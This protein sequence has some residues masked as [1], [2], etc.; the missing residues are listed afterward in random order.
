MRSNCIDV[1]FHPNYLSLTRLILSG[2]IPV[3]FIYF[4]AA[5]LYI[6]FAISITDALDGY[7]A[8]K[9]NLTTQLG[10]LLDSFA[11]KI[12]LISTGICLLYEIHTIHMLIILHL[13]FFRELTIFM[14]RLYAKYINITLKVSIL[15]KIKTLS[16]TMIFCILL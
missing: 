10:A 11:D 15:S 9:Y 3:F 2:I 13:M 12:L 6:Y 7:L 5:M 4:R 1:F 16:Q 14:L 8:R